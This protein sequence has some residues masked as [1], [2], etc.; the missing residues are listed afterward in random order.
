LKLLFDQNVRKQNSK[1]NSIE[2]LLREDSASFAWFLTVEHTRKHF[3]RSLYREIIE[4]MAFQRLNHISFLG[5]I[6]FVFPSR[7]GF[8]KSKNTRFQHTL[9]VAKLALSFAKRAGLSAC[10][11]EFEWNEGITR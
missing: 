9:G 3:A 4:D 8:Q 6:D 2:S 5:A 10:N 11:C 1:S 7:R